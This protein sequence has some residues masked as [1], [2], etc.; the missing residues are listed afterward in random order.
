MLSGGSLLAVSILAGAVGGI[1]GGQPSI[2]LV[3][4]LAAGLV[5]LLA[6]WLF[7]RRP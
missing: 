7:D 6:V 1:I 5:L 3:A 4:G 2:G